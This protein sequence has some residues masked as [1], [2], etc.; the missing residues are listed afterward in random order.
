LCVFHNVIACV[1]FGME[2]IWIG[3]RFVQ[4]KNVKW[5]DL[6]VIVHALGIV[7]CIMKFLRH[8]LPWTHYQTQGTAQYMIETFLYWLPVSLLFTM[9][10]LLLAFWIEISNARSLSGSSWMGPWMKKMLVAVNIAVLL[11][12]TAFVI[13]FVYD[14]NL[15]WV[16]NIPIAIVVL[17]V[18]IG[19]L[20]Q[21]IK[22]RRLLSFSNSTGQYNNAA[23]KKVTN[24]TITAS[25]LLI[26]ILV[27]LILDTI[28]E[29][30]DS[31]FA[32]CQSFQV[33]YRIAEACGILVMIIPFEV[34]RTNDKTPLSKTESGE[35]RN[36]NI[37]HAVTNVT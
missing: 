29:Q 37:D 3:V 35:S 34:S 21:G 28:V 7:F 33:V 9:Y 10:S 16:I 17:V 1:L 15:Y 32:V 24:M 25:S 2:G 5:S 27:L 4:F 19:F 6:K 30:N 18:T 13:C 11:L 31:D 23:L 8:S 22:M 12:T 20:V 26:F 36:P 14:P